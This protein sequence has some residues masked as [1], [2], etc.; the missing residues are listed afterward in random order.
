MQADLPAGAGAW[1]GSVVVEQL[2]ALA[3]PDDLLTLFGELGALLE[4]GSGGAGA[5][6]AAEP[7]SALGLFLRRRML[8]F[9]LLQYE[10]RPRERACT[11]MMSVPVP[12]WARLRSR[13]WR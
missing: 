12:V 2:R 11:G 8:A 7:S 5:S 9:G 6:H 4:P 3:C 13:R 1:A 10:A